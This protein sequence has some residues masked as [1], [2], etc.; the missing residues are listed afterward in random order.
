MRRS[1]ISDQKSDVCIP[2][3]RYMRTSSLRMFVAMLLTALITGMTCSPVRATTTNEWR[4]ERVVVPY[5]NTST[6]MTARLTVSERRVISA[7][8]SLIDRRPNPVYDSSRVLTWV[9]EPSAKSSMTLAMSRRVLNTLQ[10]IFDINNFRDTTKTTVVVGRTQA[11][12]QQEVRRRGCNPDLDR[13][14]GVFLMAAA[15]CN[16]RFIVINLTGYFFLVSP[17]Q[18]LTQ[19]LES[20]KEPAISR[21]SSFIVD[22]NLSGLAHEW[23]H[24]ARAASGS[25]EVQP[26]EPAWIKEG[27]AEFM[28]GIARVQTYRDKMSYKT[29]HILRLRRFADW[30]SR[31]TESLRRYRGDTFKVN[32]CEYYVGPLAVELLVADFGGLPNLLKLWAESNLQR[33]FA[34]AFE[35]VYGMTLT[36]FEQIADDYI[37][38]IA[39]AELSP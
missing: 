23:A 14:N 13:T 25:G 18:S 7:V 35:T 20:R 5:G 38:E 17:S 28:S 37:A 1:C 29:F 6:P 4:V 36:A 12:L 21:T 27:F 30:A 34:S 3:L 33:D 26:D 22:R 8:Q 9:I 31:C 15:V 16:R 19:V 32:G 24:V 39:R 2:R 10:Q 11:F